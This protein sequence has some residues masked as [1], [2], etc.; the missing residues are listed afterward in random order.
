[1]FILD[2]R[3]QHPILIYD[4]FGKR[5]PHT[6]SCWSLLRMVTCAATTYLSTAPLEQARWVVV[7]VY[8]KHLS[9]CSTLC[10]QLR[11]TWTPPLHQDPHCTV[12]CVPLL[13]SLK[14]R[15]VTALGPRSPRP[16]PQIPPSMTWGNTRF[17]D[18]PDHN[19]NRA[20]IWD[21]TYSV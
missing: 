16:L 8:W 2:V 1:M 11:W 17:L 21:T 12:H 7:A 3:D 4:P 5:T 18:L 14:P 13:K 20:G 19:N 10:P 15:Y 9:R 6:L